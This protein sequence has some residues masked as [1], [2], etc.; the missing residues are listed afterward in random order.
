MRGQ[1]NLQPMSDRLQLQQRHMLTEL[2]QCQQLSLLQQLRLVPALQI[3]LHPLFKP[4]Q[5]KE[6]LPCQLRLLQ[7]RLHI[8]R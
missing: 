2:L 7:A 6:L 1:L 5:F 8:L 3:K 4:M